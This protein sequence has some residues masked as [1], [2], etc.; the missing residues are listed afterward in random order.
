MVRH[1]LFPDIVCTSSHEVSRQR[2]GDSVWQTVVHARCRGDGWGGS[3]MENCGCSTARLTLPP[4]I[5]SVME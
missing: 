1:L 4:I 3:F 2:S 5:G